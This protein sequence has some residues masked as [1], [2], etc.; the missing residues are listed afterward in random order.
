MAVNGR[1]YCGYAL[2]VP[3]M[4][5]HKKLKLTMSM[6]DLYEAGDEPSAMATMLYR[7]LKLPDYTPRDIVRGTVFVANEQDDELLDFT[8]DDMCY[9][10]TKALRCD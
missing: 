10:F 1:Y 6:P 5:E 7:K 4:W 8:E 9:I 2:H 3:E